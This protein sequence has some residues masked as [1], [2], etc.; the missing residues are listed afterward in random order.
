MYTYENDQLYLQTHDAN[1]LYRDRDSIIF[2]SLDV[3]TLLKA[4]LRD[5]DTETKPLWYWYKA[6]PVDAPWDIL[7]ALAAYS[8]VPEI[9][10]GALKAMTVMGLGIEDIEEEG[11][12][13]VLER[14]SKAST[15]V[16]NAA[17]EYLAAHGKSVDANW[18]RAEYDLSD[19]ATQSTA[20][21]SLLRLFAR[22]DKVGGL[23]ALYQLQP[24][25]VAKS[26]LS[27]LLNNSDAIPTHV[28]RQGLDQR[29]PEIRRGVASLLS[30]RNAIDIVT[31]N[32]L[33]A[34][35]DMEIRYFGA[36]ALAKLGQALAPIDAAT[37]LTVKRPRA[38]L[39]S[40][41]S[42]DD[43]TW[44]E[45]YKRSF[46]EVVGLK[47][48]QLIAAEESIYDNAAYN[49]LSRRRFA[50]HKQDLIARVQ[51]FY[52]NLFDK[53][54]ERL[55]EVG[56]SGD[57]LTQSIGLKDY[58]VR[59]HTF[60]AIEILAEKGNGAEITIVREALS[61]SDRGAS[62][63]IFR[64]LGKFG[65]WDDIPF[66]I[67]LAKRGPRFLGLSDYGGRSR[68]CSRAAAICLIQLG[69]GRWIDLMAA[70]Y[71]SDLDSYVFAN[72]PH[73]AFLDLTNE[74]VINYLRDKREEFR[75]V[76]ALRMI[77]SFS[78]ERIRSILES[79]SAK[80]SQYF[81]N[82]IFWLDFRLSFPSEAPHAARGLISS[83][84]H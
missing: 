6:S 77:T 16:K 33:L 65:N 24:A 52:S 5:I 73:K 37:A 71:C 32:R 30:K 70:V 20:L 61:K 53:H 35:E 38:G 59:E 76:V 17:L 14:W 7:V 78:V 22:T 36:C 18:I 39:L 60:S 8:S 56:V 19:S 83:R 80:G 31:A 75:K 1:L 49:A 58:I 62:P 15:V 42:S 72:L 63:I 81:Y 12:T 28:V 54:I 45:Q 50:A 26:A 11:R 23:E 46:Y 27:A 34:D 66:V 10:V 25:S 2:G 40:P 67:A 69:K 79:Y 47:Q 51:G 3:D 82:V 13:R 57:S 55:V 48:L 84:W 41:G 9:C 43:T 4:S 68:D 44:A 64:Y 74:M 21:T 29:A